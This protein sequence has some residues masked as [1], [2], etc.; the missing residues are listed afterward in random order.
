MY[1]SWYHTSPEEAKNFLGSCGV[2]LTI[3]TFAS[4]F[5]QMVSLKILVQLSADRCV[6]VGFT[7]HDWKELTQSICS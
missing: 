1:S 5:A 6:P 7:V 2:L 3:G 4:P